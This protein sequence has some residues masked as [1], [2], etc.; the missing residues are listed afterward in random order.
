MQRLSGWVSAGLLS[1]GVSAGVLTGT[2]VAVA[3]T[4]SSPAAASRSGGGT[5]RSGIGTPK[6]QTPKAQTPK[7]QTPKAQT[8]GTATAATR[9][10][11]AMSEADLP[12]KKKTKPVSSATQSPTN[13]KTESTGKSALSAASATAPEAPMTA[14]STVTTA[15]ASSSALRLVQEPVAAKAALTAI[16][17]VNVIAKAVTNF[18]TNV[19]SAATNL[20]TNVGSVAINALQAVEMLVAGPPVLPANSTVTVRTSTILFGNGQRVQAN[21][22]FP[23]GE[24]PPEKMILLQHGLLA[25]GPMYSY[26]AANLSESTNSV[27]VTPSL[28]SNWF[29]GDDHWLGGIGMAEEIANL[30]TGNREALTQS[31][32][33]AGYATR[34]GLDP[35]TAALPEKF[36]LVGHSL[37]G[38][39]V[40]GAAGFIAETE[41]ADDLVGVVLLDAVPT[42]KTLS[43]ALVKLATYQA[44]GGQYIP[45]REIGAPTNGWNATS[46]VNETLSAAR[47][48]RFNGVVLSG[49]VHMDSMQGGNP[50]I[51]FLAYLFAGFPQ[52]QNPP[53]VQELAVD[54]LTDWFNN[55]TDNGDSLVPGT[56]IDIVDPNGSVAHGRV[57][58]TAPTPA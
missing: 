41:A 57:I 35:A 18:F 32:I 24:D 40:S 9:T 17:P 5:H 46:T 56:V 26:T 25:L 51:Q 27:V 13:H 20:V 23:D 7:A 36:A 52:A 16:N 38:N 31:A 48:G 22:Y 53:A 29:A 28:P 6:A 3:D 44:N 58:G 19:G 47:P 37:G 39:L 11:T 8:Q 43:D 42:G 34:Y 54:W 1:A 15:L 55:D 45:V 14:V 4:V 30:F 12:K 49:G 33:A 10:T 2:G 50:I 21:W